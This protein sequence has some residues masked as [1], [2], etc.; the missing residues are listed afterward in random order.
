MTV[1]KSVSVQKLIEGEEVFCPFCKRGIDVQE[2]IGTGKLLMSEI[3][4]HYVGYEV[5]GDYL[6][7][8]FSF[9]T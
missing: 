1:G 5:K 7:L 2:E 6:I 3:C 8:W 4:E 9:R